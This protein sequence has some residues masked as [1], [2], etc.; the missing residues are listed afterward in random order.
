MQKKTFSNLVTKNKKPILIPIQNI[1]RNINLKKV[2]FFIIKDLNLLNILLK[3][4]KKIFKYKM[5]F[6]KMR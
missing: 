1:N 6:K 3:Q 5:I 2:G 4:N